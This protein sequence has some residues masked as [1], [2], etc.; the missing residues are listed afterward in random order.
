MVVYFDGANINKPFGDGQ[1]DD[2][3]TIRDNIKNQMKSMPL[4]LGTV[5]NHN[6]PASQEITEVR[7]QLLEKYAP[8]KK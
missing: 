7:K 5:D 1:D 2:F 3:L 6:Y 4:S 8:N